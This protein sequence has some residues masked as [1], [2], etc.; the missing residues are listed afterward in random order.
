M[1]RLKLLSF[2]MLLAVIF[3]A[4]GP[5]YLETEPSNRIS[6]KQLEEIAKYNPAILGSLVSGL[7]SSM[8]ATGTG[9]TT[10]HND[11]GQKGYDIWSDLQSGDVVLMNKIYGW[12]GN[13]SDRTIY[14]DFTIT[15]LHYQYWRYYYRIIKSANTIINALS[16]EYGEEEPP[17]AIAKHYLGQA[18]AVRAYCYYHLALY[19]TTSYQPNQ[20]LIPL[21]TAPDQLN[22][23][24][25]IQKDIFDLIVS[26]LT[27]AINYLD[28][29]TRSSKAEIDKFVAKGLLA[30]AYAYIGDNASLE[31]AFDV[32]LDIINNGGFP[33]MNANEVMTSDISLPGGFKDINTP[34]WM[35][36]AENT[37][38]TGLGL[39]SWWG[40]MDIYSYSYAGVGD[41]KGISLDIYNRI[42]PDDVRKNQFLF[43]PA[44]WAHTAPYRK[45][46][47]SRTVMGASRVVTADYVFMRVS[48]MYLLHAEVA[49]N[50]N[51][52][53]AARGA[54]EA[55]LAKRLTDY[56]YVQ[57]L[58]GNDLKEEIF[59]QTRLELWG[60]GKSIA[61]LKRN[62]A[63]ATFGSNHMDF[64][65][66]TFSYNHPT[67]TFKIPENEIQNNPNIS[68][69][70]N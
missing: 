21:Y 61:A 27:L 5:D 15:D 9:G 68:S 6:D 19:T 25:S 45:F 67:M 37:P 36:G 49:A 8:V 56:S 42:R 41:V 18:L 59:F 31:K 48:E 28:N 62:K 55:L 1:K 3:P 26:D 57:A 35:W 13:A 65:G 7:Y 46:W 30:Y 34:G 11:F 70:N 39:I 60:E 66:G 47:A 40:Q 22:Y 20:E 4:C 14:T 29:Y 58:T 50:L 64:P 32:T 10:R 53:V 17:T 69:T 12:Y 38:E 54:L 44:S 33:I 43:N 16:N 51:R 24:K 63:I 52:E 23:P 2:I